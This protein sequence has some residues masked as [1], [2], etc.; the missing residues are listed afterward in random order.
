M[1][2]LEEHEKDSKNRYGNPFTELHK[3]M[4]EPVKILGFKHRMYRHN[5]KTTP[6]EAKGLFGNNADNA[7][8]DHIMLDYKETEDLLFQRNRNK[9]T[10]SL[11]HLV[12]MRI[13]KDIRDVVSDYAKDNTN[14]NFT[15]AMMHFV[16]RGIISKVIYDRLP[17]FKNEQ[18][19]LMLA[20]LSE[21][22]RYTRA[23]SNKGLTF[24]RDNY[25]CRKCNSIDNL[26]IYEI[27]SDKEMGLS[28]FNNDTN[29]LL[30]HGNE[31]ILCGNCLKR[32]QS[33]IPKRYRLELFLEWF[34]LL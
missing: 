4:D 13:P 22:G 5:P 25:K 26:F 29:S 33:F 10:T 11:T 20:L 30:G 1:P 6:I 23:Q 19:K 12:A 21:T 16:E 31:I 3:W 8:I 28:L 27:A 32:F 15:D 2:K 18:E 9:T 7:C 24:E 34:Y 14:G 17:K